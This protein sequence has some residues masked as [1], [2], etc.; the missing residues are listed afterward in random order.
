MMPTTIN[1]KPGTLK[2]GLS[3][4]FLLILLASIGS[5]S[6]V[7]SS[8][9]KYWPDASAAEMKNSLKIFL[10]S[11]KIRRAAVAKVRSEMH[12][13]E[14]FQDKRR[15]KEEIADLKRNLQTVNANFQSN[16]ILKVLDVQR[17]ERDE[18]GN[19]GQSKVR[20]RE[21]T[22]AKINEWKNKL[23]TK[24]QELADIRRR[25]QLNNNIIQNPE[26][27]I[28]IP[29]EYAKDPEE[30]REKEHEVLVL[31]RENMA[32]RKDIATREVVPSWVS[33]EW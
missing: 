24:E 2:Y 19:M 22:T 7:T 20:V 27:Y 15:I 4:V 23:E 10:T 32:F 11:M 1:L 18:N 16:N 3:I 9:S 13:A 6:K 29:R 12:L 31:D 33:D 21:L 8:L 14:L 5:S 28:S 25:I 17:S 30:Q 26:N